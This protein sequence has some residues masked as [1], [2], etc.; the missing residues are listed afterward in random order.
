MHTF[1]LAPS[2]FGV[3]L[4]SVSLG[5][6]RALERNGLRVHFLKPIAQPHPGDDGPERSTALIGRTMGLEPPAPLELHEVER[7]LANG[8]LDEV[9]EDIVS[10]YREAARDAVRDVG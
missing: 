8:E 2:G 10:R 6:I 3:G 7:R 5:L 9:L 4:T 1:F